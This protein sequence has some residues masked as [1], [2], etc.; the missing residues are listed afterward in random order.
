MDIFRR[1]VGVVLIVIGAVVA[2]HMIAQPLYDASS[3]ASPHNPIWSIINPFMA[4]AVVLGVIFGYIRKR[5]VEPRGRRS[6]DYPRV[7]VG[8][9]AVLRFPGRDDKADEAAIFAGIQGTVGCPACRSR[10]WAASATLMTMLWPRPSMVFTR[11]TCAG[12]FSR[13]GR[14]RGHPDDGGRPRGRDVLED[15]LAG[16]SAMPAVPITAR[17]LSAFSDSAAWTSCA[18]PRRSAVPRQRL[19]A[20]CHGASPDALPRPSASSAP[21]GSASPRRPGRAR[22][23]KRISAR[24]DDDVDLKEYALAGERRGSGGPPWLVPQT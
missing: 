24:A 21:C 22:C 17:M 10:V 20:S 6:S 5:G 13:R 2:V 14:G 8:Q 7:S 12:A 23:E 15:H 16:G 9:H 3:E 19:R 11:R 1:G 4:L 18:A